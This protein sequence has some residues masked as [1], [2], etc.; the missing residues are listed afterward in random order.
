LRLYRRTFPTAP[1]RT[2]R[3]PFD[4]VGS[5]LP[6]RRIERDLPRRHLR[7]LPFG[8]APEGYSLRPRLASSTWHLSASTSEV[9]YSP[10]PCPTRYRWHVEYYESSVDRHLQS[11]PFRCS[12]R[13]MNTVV[14][15]VGKVDPV[16]QPHEVC[17][18][19]RQAVRSV[20]CAHRASPTV[21]RVSRSATQAG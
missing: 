13:P 14:G 16:V 8:L 21:Q 6:V 10:S 15:R 12:H 5:P 18:G 3:A 19:L 2:H 4:A 11:H 20:E 7:S 9:S 1:P 17:V